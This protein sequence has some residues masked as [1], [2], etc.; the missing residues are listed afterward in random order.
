MYILPTLKG[1]TIELQQ[2][3]F[4]FYFYNNFLSK[5]IKVNLISIILYIFILKY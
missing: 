4:H 5:P 2:N 3:M 1:V